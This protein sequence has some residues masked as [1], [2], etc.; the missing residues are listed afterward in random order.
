MQKKKQPWQGQRCFP[1]CVLEMVL[2]HL[3][4]LGP[5]GC[6]PLDGTR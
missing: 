5:R 3:M 1:G 6:P 4:Q 2:L